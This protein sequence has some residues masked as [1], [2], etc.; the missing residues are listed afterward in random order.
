MVVCSN[1][2][3]NTTY[4]NYV[5]ACDEVAK[6]PYI[7]VDVNIYVFV[8]WWLYFCHN[9]NIV[10]QSPKTSYY[11]TPKRGTAMPRL[12]GGRRKNLCTDMEIAAHAIAWEPLCHLL[13]TIENFLRFQSQ[14]KHNASL[15]Y[16]M[17]GKSRL[18][19]N[20][21]IA[22]F[23]DTQS[24]LDK[25]QW[26]DTY[27]IICLYPY[28]VMID[29]ICWFSRILNNSPTILIA[30]HIFNNIARRIMFKRIQSHLKGWR[31]SPCGNKAG[32]IGTK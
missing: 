3:C 13:C 10:S 15:I 6:L 16:R 17:S 30:F 1:K 29:L 19:P 21:K 8:N 11:F 20:T 5:I 12:I 18:Q 28:W 22:N 2:T 25:N 24:Y 31:I 7:V 23:L 32:T 27:F 26:F 14:D 4:I 9:Q